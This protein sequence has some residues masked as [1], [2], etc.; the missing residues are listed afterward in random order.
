MKNWT[1]WLFGAAALVALGTSA[2][3]LAPARDASAQ[4]MQLKRAP[5]A[6]ELVGGPWLGTPGG[7]PITLASQRGKVVVLHFWTFACSNC[8]ANIPAYNR[9][10]RNFPKSQVQVISV[11]TPE[12]A[13]EH[14]PKNVERRVKA[15]NIHYPVLL[16]AKE[17]NW[18]RWNQ[19]FWPTIYIIDKEGRVHFKHEGE[20][21][22]DEAGFTRDIE[23]LVKEPAPH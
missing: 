14:V 22:S 8:L 10:D 15:L 21:G 17:V 9:I 5:L 3:L 12:F 11:H 4:T 23:T 13:F 20:F 16:D 6:T 19:Q 7:R 18:G 2:A 1:N